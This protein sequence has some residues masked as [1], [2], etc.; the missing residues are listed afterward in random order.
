MVSTACGIESTSHI[1]TV[2][3]IVCC[4]PFPGGGTAPSE[5]QQMKLTNLQSTLKLNEAQTKEAESR[6]LQVNTI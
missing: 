2:L 4:F 6:M 3:V 1:C 5:R